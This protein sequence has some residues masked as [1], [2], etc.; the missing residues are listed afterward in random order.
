MTDR[1][2]A[3]VFRHIVSYYVAAGTTPDQ[4]IGPFATKLEALL[5]AREFQSEHQRDPNF[6]LDLTNAH[7]EELVEFLR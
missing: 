3:A 5:A 6:V 7:A 4:H 1:K 2:Y